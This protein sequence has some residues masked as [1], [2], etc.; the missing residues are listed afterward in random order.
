M[1]IPRIFHPVNQNDNTLTPFRVYKRY[2]I[3]GDSLPSNY[4]NWKAVHSNLI[5]PVG[6]D[7]VY[8]DPV[9]SDGTYQHIIWESIK[10]KF[11]FEHNNQRYTY[12]FLNYSASMMSVPYMDMGESI[13][14]G[15]VSVTQSNLNFSITDDQNGNLYDPLVDTGSFAPRSNLVAYWGFNE[16]FDRFKFREG[17][18]TNST[19]PYSSHVYAVDRPSYVKNVT[20]QQG[21]T[22]DSIPSGMSAL[23]TSSSYILT[24]HKDE[25]NFT[26]NED[27]SLSMW[28]KCSDSGST[29]KFF[30]KNSIIEKMEYGN[31]QNYQNDLSV[32]TLHVSRSF[33]A[34]STNIYPYQLELANGVPIFKCSD[35]INIVTCSGSNLSDSSWHHIA[36][37]K[38]NFTYS[39]WQDSVLMNS[40]TKRLVG[41]ANKHSL[42]FGNLNGELDEIRIYDTALSGQEIRTLANNLNQSLYQTAVVGNVFYRS[43][44]IVISG[45]DPKYLSSFSNDWTLKYRGTHTIYQRELMVRIKRGDFNLSQNPTALVNYKSDMLIDEFVSGSL[46]PYVTQIGF[47]DDE[48]NLLATAKL[49]RPLQMTDQTD[50]AIVV[51]MDM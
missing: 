28:I 19:L 9:N 23:F 30:N 24:E 36:V 2:T 6:S 12:K 16:V 34:E 31:N 15:S 10:T 46:F 45:F 37:V 5:T 29:Y 22:I 14:P 25:F 50:I 33:V 38:D 4:R 1:A 35:G 11:A 39:F 20:F 42:Q 48:K 7:I 21:V 51:R 47:Y 40:S 44:N 32:T 27:F 8:N 3:T 18:L 43:G 41:I 49:N 26:D 17:N 13:K